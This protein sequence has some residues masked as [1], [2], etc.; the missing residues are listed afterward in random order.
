M[1]ITRY[2]VDKTL[3]GDCSFALKRYIEGIDGV[4]AVDLG[5]SAREIRFDEIAV[6]ENKLQSIAR[7][8]IERLG[9]RIEE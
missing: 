8:S 7:G 6:D 5:K 1:K 4:D 3:C 9:Y 2:Q